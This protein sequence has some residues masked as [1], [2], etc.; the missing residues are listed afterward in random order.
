LTLDVLVE[1]HRSELEAHCRRIV[2]AADAEDAVQEAL[3]RAW[4]ALPSLERPG[5]ARA[6]LYRIATNASLDAVARRSSRVVSIDG[7]DPHDEIE[8]PDPAPGPAE[9]YERRESLEVA[10][11]RA[12]RLLSPNQRAVLIMREALGYS[13]R[14]T[15]DALDTSV[16]AVNSS[17]QRARRALERDGG[18]TR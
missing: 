10:V 8:L 14:E 5:S 1:R 12:A 11:R 3:L 17:L 13:A 18:Q 2:G 4:R 9:R 16:A 6:W 7:A 15:A